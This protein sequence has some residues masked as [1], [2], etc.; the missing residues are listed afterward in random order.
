[1]SPDLK[2]FCN[3]TAGFIRQGPE[4]QG[5]NIGAQTDD[6]AVCNGRDHGMMTEFLPFMYIGHMKLNDGA[7]QHLQSIGDRIA[8]MGPGPGVDQD[9]VIM[10]QISFMDF[11]HHLSLVVG[12]KAG[13]SD[14]Q[15][16]GQRK[17]LFIDLVQSDSAILPGIAFP[18]HIVV[19]T[20]KQH[21]FFHKRPPRDIIGV[22]RPFDP[23]I[24]I[25]EVFYLC[26]Y[27]FAS[28]KRKLMEKT[29]QRKGSQ[30]VT[31]RK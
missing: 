27:G 6:D 29:T 26:F 15:F 23:D 24:I 31:K 17:N 30:T 2:I 22:G 11:I 25:I 18:E 20:V 14:T 19:D 1:M 13:D 5:V 3:S 7:L 4:S 8:V 16:P 12:L 28:I 10:F 9:A 21:E